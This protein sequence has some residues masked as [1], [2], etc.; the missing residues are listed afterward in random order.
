MTITKK[1]ITKYINNSGYRPVRIRE[2][3][4]KLKVNTQ[5]YRVFR[6][7]I[8][9][10]TSDGKLAR[11]KHGRIGLCEPHLTV[12]GTL[13]ITRSGR[14]F[15]MPED[16]SPEIVIPDRLLAGALDGDTVR[17]RLT[18]NYSR[19]KPTG[20]ILQVKKRT[21][22]Q[23][24]GSFKSSRFGDFVRPDNPR[25]RDDIQVTM[26]K[27]LRI[28][29]GM[30][31]VVQLTPW[32]DPYSPLQGKIIKVLG[33]PGDPGVDIL[34]V[35]HQ[36]NLPIE[37]PAAVLREADRYAG[38]ISAGELQR[39]LDL[40]RK[41]IFTIDPE[42]AGDHDDAISIERTRT[43]YRLGVHIADVSHYVTVGGHLDKEAR[44]RSFSAYLVDRVIPM[45]P[46][47]LSNNLCSL[48]EKEDRLT[49]SVFIDLDHQ[50][51]ILSYDLTPS[52]IRSQASLN[53]KQ[54]Q[55]FL[56]NGTGFEKQKRIG[57]KLKL[58]DEVA[59]LQLTQRLNAGSL[60]LESPEYKVIL[61]NGGQVVAIEKRQRQMSNRIIEEFM[62]LANKVVAREFLRKNIPILYRVHP[63]P[64]ET[65]I[66]TFAAFAETL[67]FKPSFGSPPQ[68]KLI[69]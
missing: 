49:L 44:K 31:V 51:D 34:T 22:K 47:R 61:D 63:P 33:R 29:E 9:E 57:D 21:T 69:S 11:L 17:V 60:D 59:R 16:D 28:E 52:V 26:P 40:R 13:S 42:D 53:Y 39:R 45:L 65:K 62:L 35:I 5:E 66:A 37:F 19:S 46:E 23:L 54:V 32:T 4:R 36:Y 7:L 12:S 58:T 18:G 56:D 2:L 27:S 14:G 30:K 15:V 67:G 55:Q 50:G 1:T 6:R 41:I 68:V 43:G 24:V 10:L 8:K 64:D 38:R 25:I 20:E 48:Q 3:S